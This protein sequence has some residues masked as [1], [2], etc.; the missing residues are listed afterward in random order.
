[1][2][3]YFVNHDATRTLDLLANTPDGVLVSEETV[4]D[5]QLQPND[6]INLRLQSTVDHRYHSIPFKFIGIAREFPTAPKDSFLIANSTYLAKATASPAEEVVLARSGRPGASAS[7]LQKILVTEPALKVT[8]I[9]EVQS[10]ISSSLTSVNLRAL[11]RLELGFGLLLI[12][13]SASLVLGLGFVERRRTFAILT[14]LGAKPAQLGAFLRGEGLLITGAGLIF[15]FLTGVGIAVVL[16]VMLAGVFD[17]PPETI[18]MPIG[19]IL[20]IIFGA[21]TASTAVTIGFERLHRSPD[22]VALRAP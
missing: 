16:V 17:P 7:A 12:T 4:Q 10:L 13:T 9:G 22:V 21:V 20:I 2:N 1:V 5:F 14:A 19:Y 11:T 3:A 18:V 8:A 15:G 6:T